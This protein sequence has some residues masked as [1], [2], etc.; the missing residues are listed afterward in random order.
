MAELARFFGIVIAMFYREHGRAHIHVFYSGDV[1]VIAVHDGEV[2]SGSI[3][4]PALRLVREWISLH[5]DELLE[6]WARARRGEN[7]RRIRPLR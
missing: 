3:P 4:R 2:L 6:A 5:E 7:V 1:A